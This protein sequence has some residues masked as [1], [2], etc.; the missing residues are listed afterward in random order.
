MAVEAVLKIADIKNNF[1]DLERIKVDGKP[2]GS[3]EDTMLV[4]GVALDQ[5]FSHPH[6]ERVRLIVGIRI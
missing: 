4:N 3:L 2:G 5:Q 6:M 1:I